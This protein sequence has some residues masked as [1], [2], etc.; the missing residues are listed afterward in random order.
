M[1][2][3]P[4]HHYVLHRRRRDS[5]AP[6]LLITSF[7]IVVGAIHARHSSSSLRS[8]SSPARFMR[9]LLNL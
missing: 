4:P 6:L 5:C 2:A 8:A 3:T 7:C 1:R 9:W